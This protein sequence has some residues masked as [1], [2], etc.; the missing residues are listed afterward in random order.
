MSEQVD[1]PPPDE[2]VE[3]QI[4]EE[5]ARVH[6]ESYGERVT[7]VRVALP[8]D[9]V[10]VAMDVVLSLAERTLLEA[11][12]VDPVKTSREIYQEAI[13]E[14]FIAIVERAT[15]RR[16]IGFASRTVLTVPDPW[17]VEIFRLAPRE[18]EGPDGR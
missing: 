1:V 6:H 12:R 7:N 16:V 18:V 13:G 5:I 3:R 8:E 15:G 2:A 17:S 10:Y 4:A 14:V 9:M 11:G